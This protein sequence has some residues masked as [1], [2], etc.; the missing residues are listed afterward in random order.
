[1]NQLSSRFAVWLVP[2]VEPP[3]QNGSNMETYQLKSQT[4]LQPGGWYPRCRRQGGGFEPQPHHLPF[5]SADFLPCALVFPSLAPHALGFLGLYRFLVRLYTGSL[6]KT[7]G[8]TGFPRFNC[9]PDLLGGLDRR[10]SGS[11]FYRSDPRSGPVLIT[12]H[13]CGHSSSRCY[14]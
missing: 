11:I 7:A 13:N 8:S 12:M 5:F 14:F 6:L 1:M 9:L 10:G 3:V 2:P 4:Q